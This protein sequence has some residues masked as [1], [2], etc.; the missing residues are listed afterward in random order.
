MQDQ[1][2]RDFETSLWTG[3]AENYREKMDQENVVVAIPVQ[4]FL[5][6]GGAAIEAVEDTP[7]WSSVEMENVHISRPEHGLITLAYKAIAKRENDEEAYEAFCTS[8]Y[9]RLDDEEWRVIQHSQT[10]A[11]TA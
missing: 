5:L 9:R 6:K 3:T 1:E 7:R 10:V 8:T 4:P 11:Q 2:I